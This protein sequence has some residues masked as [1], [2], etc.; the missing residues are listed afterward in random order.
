MAR[1][2]TLGLTALLILGGCASVPHPH[3]YANDG[4]PATVPPHLGQEA[5]AT[6]RIEPL[7]PYANRPYFALGRR[8]VPLTRDVPF[9]QRGIAS[10]YGRQY[11]GNRTAS[12]EP[13]DMF[14]MTAA[15]PT[16]PIPSYARVTNLRNGRSV[17][18]RV[19]DRGP[20]LFDRVIDLSYAAATRLGI[21][22]PG[23]G[24]V[25]V[26]R[27][28]D[29]EIADGSWKAG[30]PD[31]KLAA[32]SLPPGTPAA[33]GPV[34]AAAPAGGVVPAT[35]SPPVR[36]TAADSPPPATPPAD[37]DRRNGTP[38]PVQAL[39][40]ADHPP[41]ELQPPTGG[42]ATHWAVQLGAFSS[43][44]HADALRDRLD[45]L[46]GA[47]QAAPLPAQARQARVARSDRLNRVLIGD[48]PDR[49]SAQ[50]MARRLSRFLGRQAIVFAYGTESAAG[51]SSLPRPAQSAR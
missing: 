18:V 21:A 7:D 29:R 28:T 49:T 26:E 2:R 4:P 24:E 13:Y 27:I 48:T 3:Y 35:Y 44:A 25:E 31:A 51:S 45:L 43:P 33:P 47:P 9:R 16:L 34:V 6:P 11:Q 23:T 22:G 12:G 10:W 1:T 50:D 17:I 8:Y 37:D 32:L 14:A 38:D 15:H 39:L 5:D 41:P 40:D 42:T 46:L 36:S 30:R 20:F 19:N